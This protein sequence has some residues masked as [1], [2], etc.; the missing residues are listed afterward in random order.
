MTKKNPIIKKD[1]NIIVYAA[2]KEYNNS[3]YT[4]NNGK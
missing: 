2:I 4:Y 1:S 3:L